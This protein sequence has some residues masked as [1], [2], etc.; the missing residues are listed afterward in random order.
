MFFYQ[1]L[2]LSPSWINQLI[3]WV[4]NLGK[5]FIVLWEWFLNDI[6]SYVCEKWGDFYCLEAIW[7]NVWKE[8]CYLECYD[9]WFGFIKRG[10]LFLIMSHSSSCYADLIDVACEI[11]YSMKVV[12]GISLKIEF[13]FWSINCS[14]VWNLIITTVIEIWCSSIHKRR[15]L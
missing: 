5:S 14:W 9:I 7:W 13:E 1:V 11:F 10:S 12:Y 6:G 3:V 4:L 8:R 2:T 15:K